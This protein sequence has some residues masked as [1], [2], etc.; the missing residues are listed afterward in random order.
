MTFQR[1]RG[2]I[3]GSREAC[4]LPGAISVEHEDVGQAL[5]GRTDSSDYVTFIQSRSV[6]LRQE[7]SVSVRVGTTDSE[8]LSESLGLNNER[9]Q[10][11]VSVEEG[12]EGVSEVA[13]VRD[14]L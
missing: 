4:G 8:G 13:A 12:A 3:R 2:R 7:A 14:D 6:Q 5:A 1:G 11:S 9:K 10:L